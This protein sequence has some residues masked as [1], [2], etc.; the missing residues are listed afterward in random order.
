[1]N[2]RIGTSL[3]TSVHAGERLPASA[4]FRYYG[5]SSRLFDLLQQPEEILEYNAEILK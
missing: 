3:L 1:M 4:T 5:M 2:R